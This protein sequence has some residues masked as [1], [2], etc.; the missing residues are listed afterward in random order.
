[1]KRNTLFPNPLTFKHYTIVNETT[2][3]PEI[4]KFYKLFSLDFENKKTHVRLISE[5]YEDLDL[6]VIK[7]MVKSSYKTF[8]KILKEPNNKELFIELRDLHLIMNEKINK[9]KKWELNRF[10]NN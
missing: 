2:K 6:L 3:P 8:R 7:N 1:M 9:A 5:E 10:L 4:P